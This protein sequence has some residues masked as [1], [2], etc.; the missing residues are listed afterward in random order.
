MILLNELHLKINKLD[1]VIYF[2]IPSTKK[3]L[4][5]MFS[6]RRR[7]YSIKGY[8][9]EDVSSDKDEYDNRDK[10]DYFI[11]K[12]DNRIIGTLRLIKDD[13]LPMEKDCFSFKEP[14][15]I[16]KFSKNQRREISRLVIIPYD[17]EKKQYLPRNIVLLFLVKSLIDFSSENNIY[18]GYS[19]VTKSL[20]VKLKKL[21]MPIHII[22]KY[23]QIYP[24]N[25]L[26]YPYFSKKDNPIIP[27]YYLKEEV[28]EYIDGLL[29]KGIFKIINNNKFVLKSS[30]YNKILKLLG[31]I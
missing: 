13:N 27:I 22:N 23:K 3:E 24:P 26:L 8:L 16:K 10:S 19:F 1:K 21:K 2:G 18:A 30:L 31:I 6:L 25:G 9:K 20:Y 4:M 12:I 7:M 29:K 5:D 28:E 11:A 17:K 14:I 15:A